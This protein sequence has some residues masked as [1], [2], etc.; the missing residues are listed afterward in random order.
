MK[1]ITSISI[2]LLSFFSLQSQT[3]VESFLKNKDSV[4]IYHNGKG[5]EMIPMVRFYLFA[6]NLVPDTL[7]R[8]DADR[9]LSQWNRYVLG[10][11]ISLYD[12]YKG[13][14][15]DD[16][17]YLCIIE[18]ED[19]DGKKFKLREGYPIHSLDF[20][21]PD[22]VVKP[23]IVY[24]APEDKSFDSVWRGFWGIGDNDDINHHLESR[25]SRRKFKE[26][27]VICFDLCVENAKWFLKGDTLYTGY[28]VDT[29]SKHIRLR[30][31]QEA[32]DD[33]H[34]VPAHYL[35]RIDNTCRIP[36]EKRQK[37]VRILDDENFYHYHHIENGG[38]CGPMSYKDYIDMFGY[39]FVS[40]E[41]LYRKR[42]TENQYF[43]HIE[44]RR[45]LSKENCKIYSVDKW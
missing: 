44:Y 38:F 12:M 19:M 4:T 3:F 9:L 33:F 5:R 29:A 34:P 22:L 11:T 15:F 41:E 16:Y 23:H 8:I 7:G 35:N 25:Y 45:F 13:R 18:G 20:P 10:R 36:V 1:P 31:V 43:G 42:G 40:C 21:E 26:R 39:P 24:Y 27:K 32:L 14:N 28:V 37:I 30:T 6:E 2:F 17:S